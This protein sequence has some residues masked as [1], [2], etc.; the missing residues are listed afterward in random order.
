MNPFIM[1]VL[2]IISILT[3]CQA[4][5]KKPPINAPST[6][7]TIQLAEAAV[8]ISDSM[9]QM[10]QVEKNQL[11]HSKPNHLAIPNIRALQVRASVDWSGPI[12]E[13][14]A[15]I[16]KAANYKF[17]TIGKAPAIPI[18]VNLT[19]KDDTL[20]EILINLD[21]QAGKKGS[22]HVYPSRRMVELHYAKF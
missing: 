9:Y 7:A 22:I 8:S 6:D 11:P 21:Y 16:A 5:Y 1:A 18:L 19:V 2:C 12:E 13:I 3:G 17:H 10:A 20:V 4:N 15:R 14:T